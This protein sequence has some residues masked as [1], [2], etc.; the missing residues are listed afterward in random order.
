MC[1]RHYEWRV[2]IA[3]HV[4]S[5]RPRHCIRTLPALCRFDLFGE[6]AIESAREERSSRDRDLC[7][8]SRVSIRLAIAIW[9][10]LLQE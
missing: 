6:I 9:S 5:N 2:E 8:C 1:P 7:G 10:L 4:A 3:Y